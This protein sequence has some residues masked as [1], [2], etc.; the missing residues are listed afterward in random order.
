[1]K[2]LEPPDKHHLLAAQGWLELGNCA[3]A[4]LE[5][6][7]ITLQHAGHPDV[8]SVRRRIYSRNKDWLA[9][10]NIAK[11]ICQIQPNTLFSRIHNAYDISALKRGLLETDLAAAPIRLPYFFAVPYNLACYACQLGDLE[12]AWEWF[13]MALEMS[14]EEEIRKLA[15]NDPDLEPLWGKIEGI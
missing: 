10:L 1:M 9:A 5:L 11:T 2:P 3:E 13:K 7:K 4:F 8:L 6:E 12:E 14:N 15:L